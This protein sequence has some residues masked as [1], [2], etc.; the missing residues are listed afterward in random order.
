MRIAFYAPFKPL[1]HP[2]PSGDRTIG[3]SLFTWLREQGH[4]VRE[5]SRLRT[6]W[7]FRHPLQMAASVL[8]Q[9]KV[10]AQLQKDPV[11]CWFTHHC[12][13]K[14][15][16]LLGP[17]IRTNLQIPYVLFQPSYATKYK[18]KPVTAP[19]FYLNRRAL[20][21]ADCCLT[22]RRRDMKDLNRLIARD[23]LFFIPP[24]VSL[25][26]FS[27]DEQARVRLRREWQAGARTVILS[28]AMF[29]DDVKSLG[30]AR[31]LESCSRLQARGEQFLLVIAGDGCKRDWL[32]EMARRLPKDSVR[33]VG[34]LQGQEMRDFYSA[35]DFFVFPG[36]NESL[37]MVYLEAQAC[38]LPV[39]A[40]DNGGIAGVV[41]QGKTGFLTKLDHDADFDAAIRR[42]LQDVPLRLQM[43]RAAAAAVRKNHDLEKNYQ[44]IEHILQRLVGDP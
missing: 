6:R 18:K 13:Y 24:A 12:Y 33:F 34:R 20:L 14:A 41:E 19:G 27:R 21:A 2:R 36:I 37:G 16:D 26:R 30:L 1:G 23:K 9:Q 39:V 4:Q 25:Q 28:A 42:L 8:E 43:G 11:D 5:I 32:E 10:L 3:R 44:Q 15:P 29:R 31:V 22:N 40:Y 7:I 38:G 35:G 17:Y